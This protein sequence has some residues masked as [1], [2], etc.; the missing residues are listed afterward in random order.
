MPCIGEPGPEVT[1]ET[2]ILSIALLTSPGLALAQKTDAD[3][4]DAFWKSGGS[5][6]SGCSNGRGR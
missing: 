2:I 6:R 3:F 4:I 1:H 5:Y